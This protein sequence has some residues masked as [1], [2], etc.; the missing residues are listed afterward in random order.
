MRPHRS[1]LKRGTFHCANQRAQ[2]LL[3]KIQNAELYLKATLNRKN[4]YSSAISALTEIIT[5]YGYKHDKATHVV[6]KTNKQT[7]QKHFD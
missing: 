5:N 7:K 4:S 1:S 3:M 2:S 6:K